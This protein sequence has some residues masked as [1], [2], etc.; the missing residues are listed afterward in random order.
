M[1]NIDITQFDISIYDEV[2]AL[3]QQCDG[4]G[5]S[6]A[7]SRESIKKYLERNQGMSFVALSSGK[8]VGVIL[9]GHD[10]RRGYI[11]HLSVHP[12]FRRQGLAR[13]LVDCSIKALQDSGIQKCHLFIFNNNQGGLAFWENIGWKR[14]LDLSIVSKQIEPRH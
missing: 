3:W 4:V 11:H 8:V 6:D 9:A 1:M 12:D 5:L 10:G 13:R 7:D 2:F 14:R